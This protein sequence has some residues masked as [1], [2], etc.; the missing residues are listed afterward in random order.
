LNC[1]LPAVVLDAR[2][3]CSRAGTLAVRTVVVATSSTRGAEVMHCCCV[4]RVRNRNVLL[5][6]RVLVS[7]D[8]L[9]EKFG[10]KSLS[11]PYVISVLR[12]YLHTQVLGSN[13]SQKLFKNKNMVRQD[14]ASGRLCDLVWRCSHEKSVPRL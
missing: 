7:H 9:L 13:F 10:W 6:F 11:L 4:L 5:R 8:V 1:R 2:L 12:I 14:R 3:L